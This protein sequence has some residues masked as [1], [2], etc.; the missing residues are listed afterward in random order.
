MRNSLLCGRVVNAMAA[1][2]GITVPK[3]IVFA[4]YKRLPS[5]HAPM[6]ACCCED[7]CAILKIFEITQKVTADG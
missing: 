1:A 6:L 4:L 7:M 5:N 3:L 2:L